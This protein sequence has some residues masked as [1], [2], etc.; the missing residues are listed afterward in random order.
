LAALPGRI[1]TREAEADDLRRG[2]G[3]R[4]SAVPRRNAGRIGAGTGG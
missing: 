4:P 1:Q 2:A 3:L